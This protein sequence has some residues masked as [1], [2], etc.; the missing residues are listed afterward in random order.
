MG[1]AQDLMESFILKT[2]EEIFSED[3]RKIVAPHNK[4]TPIDKSSAVKVKA[5]LDDITPGV[6]SLEDT[7]AITAT[8][9]ANTKTAADV[10][11]R[12][13]KTFSPVVVVSHSQG[14]LL[15]NLAWQSDASEIEAILRKKCES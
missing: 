14:N 12:D 9:M 3:F 8:T 10:L 15:A 5:Y 4:S 6:N 1:L 7:G 13:M 11:A 2:S